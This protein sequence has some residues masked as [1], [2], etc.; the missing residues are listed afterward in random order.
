VH[1]YVGPAHVRGQPLPIA[2]VASHELD[3]RMQVSGS[4]DIVSVHL[5][6]EAVIDDDISSGGK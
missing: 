1:H 6:I 5:R 4:T 3:V 2:D